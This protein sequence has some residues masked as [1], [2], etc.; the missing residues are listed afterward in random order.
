LSPTHT[1]DADATRLPATIG[2]CRPLSP[3][4]KSR[5]QCV[6]FTPTTRF[7]LTVEWS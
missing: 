2:D 1:Y 4:V 7:N 3:T 6:V 5:C